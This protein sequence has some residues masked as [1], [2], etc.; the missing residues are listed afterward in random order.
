MRF[1]FPVEV[2]LDFVQVKPKLKSE[3]IK[4]VQEGLG[5]VRCLDPL[6][7]GSGGVKNVSSFLRQRQ[8]SKKIEIPV[9]R[10]SA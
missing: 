1:E 4:E 6:S 10:N 9:L 8:G 3:R 5:S 7:F 2:R